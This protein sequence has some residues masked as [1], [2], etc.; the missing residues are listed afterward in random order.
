MNRVNEKLGQILID[1]ENWRVDWAAAEKA[2]EF[3]W[4]EEG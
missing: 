1:N 2:I 4:T 3:P